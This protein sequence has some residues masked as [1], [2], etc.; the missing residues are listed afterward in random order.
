MRAYHPPRSLT[1][2]TPRGPLRVDVYG[3]DGRP[4]HLLLHGIPGW[5]G[6]WRRVAAIL[7][8]DHQVFVP[9]LLGFGE[10]APAATDIHAE[11]QAAVLECLLDGLALGPVHLAGFD[12]GGP[13]AVSLYA[14]RPSGVASLAL[15][16][17]N[18][19]TDP[20]IPLLLQIARLPMIGDAAFRVMFGRAGLSM[21]WPAA[22][23]N[24][25]AFPKPQFSEA[26]RWPHGITA[27]RT[28]FLDSLRDLKR[29]YGPVEQTLGQI[30]A[31]AVVVWG[32]SDPFFSLE[33]GKR[34]AAAI[35]GAAFRHV[36]HCGHFIPEEFPDLTAA[37]IG[38]LAREVQRGY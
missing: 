28:I 25:D 35:P 29:L 26:L 18:V 23:R 1:V 5:R 34:T 8:R 7:A 10:S 31:P 6:T 24:R 36:S 27:T 2:A 20:P 4:P 30:T 17:T 16:A 37:V 38:D 21:M 9:D 22:V 19:F 14:R 11:G 15:L 32:D 33:V 12:F 13:T 3:D